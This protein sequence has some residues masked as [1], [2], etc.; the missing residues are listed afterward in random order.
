MVIDW[1]RS[2]RVDVSKESDRI[3]PTVAECGAVVGSVAIVQLS[4]RSGVPE[5]F[6]R[7]AQIASSLDWPDDPRRD[8][9]D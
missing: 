9:C 4:T 3:S 6:S 1:I 5:L 8:P 7:P 2:D